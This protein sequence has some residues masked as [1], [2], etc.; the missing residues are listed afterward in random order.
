MNW[1]AHEISG[2]S[3]VFSQQGVYWHSLTSDV[4]PL[5][6][7]VNTIT[8]PHTTINFYYLST[9]HTWRPLLTCPLFGSKGATK[10]YVL[11]VIIYFEYKF[12]SNCWHT[13]LFIYIRPIYWYKICLVLQYNNA[14]RSVQN[15]SYNWITFWALSTDNVLI[16]LL[17]KLHDINNWP[18]DT[19]IGYNFCIRRNSKITLYHIIYY[20]TLRCVVSYIILYYIISYPFISYIISCLIIYHIMSCRIISYIISYIILYIISYII[21]Y[22]IISCHVVSYHIS[23]HIMYHIILYYII[24]YYIIL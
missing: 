11:P 2:T 10:C 19:L 1:S 9:S 16:K 13:E 7:H 22:H 17:K 20:I 6:P 3:A 23:Y 21:L 4:T 8:V 5:L 24:S 12:F 14:I 15:A 18:C